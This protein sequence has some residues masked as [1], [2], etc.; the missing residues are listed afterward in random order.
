M[1]GVGSLEALR[2]A[3]LRQ[4]QGQ[5]AKALDIAQRISERELELAREEAGK[6]R[7]Q[8]IAKAQPAVEMEKKKLT[9]AA[10]MEARR[11]LLNKK[12]ELVSRLFAEVERTLEEARGSKLYID[13]VSKSIADGVASIGGDVIVEFG[14]KDRG[15]FT[16]EVISSIESQVVKSMGAEMKLEFRCAGDSISAGV[17]IKSSDGKVVVDSSFSN[18]IKRLK[19]EM[20]NEVSEIL[21]KD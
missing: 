4:A 12:E 7:D 11:R 2:D 20:R 9:A 17:V 21:L 19:E 15:I 1:G 18:L 13:I 8:L 10:E 3:I 16:S 5:A 14:E 6:L